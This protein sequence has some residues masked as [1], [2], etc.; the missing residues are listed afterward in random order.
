MLPIVFIYWMSMRCTRN[1]EVRNSIISSSASI[2]HIQH[3]IRSTVAKTFCM[4]PKCGECRI[5]LNILVHCGAFVRWR[6]HV[7]AFSPYNKKDPITVSSTC[8]AAIGNASGAEFLETY[9]AMYVQFSPLHCPY[10]L[11][12]IHLTRSR[13]HCFCLVSSRASITASFSHYSHQVL[14]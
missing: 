14:L 4:N 13:A 1:I 2:F 8:S 6:R 7:Y 3:S 9:P 5:P 12:A 11:F 10:Q